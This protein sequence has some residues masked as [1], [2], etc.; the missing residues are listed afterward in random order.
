MKTLEDGKI[1]RLD[2]TGDIS[3]AFIESRPLDDETIVFDQHRAW[4]LRGY[5]AEETES[6]LRYTKDDSYYEFSPLTLEAATEIFP[7]T[8]RVFKDLSVL[9]EFARKAIHLAESYKVN[10]APEEVI[11]F[12][13]SEEDEVLA[14]IKVTDT[15]DMFYWGQGDWKEV[16]EDEDLPTVYDQELIDVE[17]TDIGEALDLWKSATASGGKL[18]KEDILPLAALNQ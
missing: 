1:Y 8:I 17:P 10:T 9:E 15:G 4:N 2:H 7:N 18:T 5:T 14:L 16:G 12:T 6:G 13:I 11:S 3:A